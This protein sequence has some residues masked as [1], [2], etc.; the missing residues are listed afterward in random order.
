MTK[1]MSRVDAAVLMRN[2]RE[3]REQM[4]LDGVLT[5]SDETSLPNVHNV[6]NEVPANVA[7]RGNRVVSFIRKWLA[8]VF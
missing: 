1:K 8:K 6:S 4:K 2:I 5:H 7:A 3:Q